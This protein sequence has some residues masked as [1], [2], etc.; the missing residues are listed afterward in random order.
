MREKRKFSRGYKVAL[1]GASSDP[2]KYGNII[3]RNLKGKGYTVFP[4]NP[5]GGVIEGLK[6]YKSLKDLEETPDVVNV[7]TK[8]E[9]S[10]NVLEQ[11]DSLGFPLIWF[12]EGSW[13]AKVKESLEK[14]RIVGILDAC[15]MVVTSWNNPP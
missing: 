2:S 8:P 1:A 10:I 9:V 12:Q 15:I 6:V 14:K 13:D 3:L 5:K 7:V 4:V 11:A